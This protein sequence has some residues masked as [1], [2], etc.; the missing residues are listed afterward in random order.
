[1]S[2]VDSGARIVNISLGAY[3]TSEL[4]IR[5][6]DYATS[7]GAVL[8]ASAGNDQA[9]QLTWPA[10]D[11][12]VVSVGAVDGREQQVI[13]SNS[14]EQ[15]QISAPGY[16]VLSAWV[17]GERV[18]IDGT[19]ASAP[20]V[21]GAIAAV[22]SQYPGLSAPQA[23]QIIAQ[24]VSDAGPAGTDPDYGGGILNLGWAM[25]WNDTSRIDPAISSHWL[26]PVTG[27]MEFVVQNRSGAGVSGLQ[28][29]V[30]TSGNKTEYDVPWLAPGGIYVV[31][32]PVDQAA[33]REEGRLEFRTRLN[34]PNG[35]NDAAPGNNVKTS[36]LSR[37][38]PQ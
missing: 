5:A 4:L 30:N 27:Q 33:L 24:R 34:V 36:S 23:W 37:R 18:L 7:M 6:I 11:P 31:R 26:N 14:G 22:M 10:A 21:A 20:V 17:N 38:Q 13:F 3:G 15:L 8:V 29:N 25:N 32:V 19:S 1:V 12:R 28:L 35:I 9:T 2:A 16:G